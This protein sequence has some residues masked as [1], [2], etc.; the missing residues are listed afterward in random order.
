MSPAQMVQLRGAGDARMDQL[1]GAG[2]AR[3]AEAQR[4]KETALAAAR[5][6]AGEMLESALTERDAAL[7]LVCLPP[8]ALHPPPRVLSVVRG[9]P[10]LRGPSPEPK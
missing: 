1:R 8:R 6:E 7:L 4:E 3:V 5:Q 9:S 2:E 10:P